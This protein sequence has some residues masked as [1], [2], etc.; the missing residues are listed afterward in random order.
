ME[1]ILL[2][3]LKIKKSRVFTREQ[4]L[5]D[6]IY[7]YFGKK[8]NFPLIIK[9]IKNKGYQ[10]IFEAWQEVKKADCQDKIKLFMWKLGQNK[11]IFQY[12]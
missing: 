2:K 4:E 8:I 10:A 11:V 1:R 3:E 12:K 5:A 9:S 6:Q 7:F